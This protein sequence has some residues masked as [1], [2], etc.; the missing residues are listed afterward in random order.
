MTY[1]VRFTFSVGDTTQALPVRQFA[2][3]IRAGQIELVTLNTKF[4]AV[5]PRWGHL[6][7]PHLHRNLSRNALAFA[8]RFL[9]LTVTH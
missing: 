1:N 8:S 3:I 5:A 7:H 2:N 6:H 4:R 9:H